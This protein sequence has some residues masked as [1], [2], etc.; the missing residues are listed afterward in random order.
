MVFDG[1]PLISMPPP[2][3]VPVT[4][5]FEP[6]TFK[7]LPRLSPDHSKYLGKFLLT[8]NQRLRSYRLDSSSQ[9]SYCRRCLTFTFDPH[10]LEHVITSSFDYHEQ[11]TSHDFHDLVTL[12]FDL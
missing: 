11:S 1:E 4:L 12:P 2:M 7:T 8:P 3:N 9:A 10:D 6:V 5:T